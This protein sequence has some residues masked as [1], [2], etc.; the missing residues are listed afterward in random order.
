MSSFWSHGW[1]DAP[2]PAFCPHH[3]CSYTSSGNILVVFVAIV[4]VL[5]ALVTLIVIGLRRRARKKRRE[6]Q[7]GPEQWPP[8]PPGYFPQSPDQ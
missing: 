2:N 4:L 1:A 5:A 3:Q 7:G 8:S 6:G